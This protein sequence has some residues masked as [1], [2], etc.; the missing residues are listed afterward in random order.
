[1]HNDGHCPVAA[2][3][4]AA[5]SNRA[6]SMLSNSRRQYPTVATRTFVPTSP[7]AALPPTLTGPAKT[8][9][10][11]SLPLRTAMIQPAELTQGASNPPFSRPST[12]TV[13]HS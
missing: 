5:S 7:W 4:H 11:D 2:A 3:T 10:N 12:Y 13:C 8:E 1:M 6:L 9:G